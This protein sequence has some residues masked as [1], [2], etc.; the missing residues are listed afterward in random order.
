MPTKQTQTKLVIA[1]GAAAVLGVILW[2]LKAAARPIGDWV[3]S[4][5]ECFVESSGI[6][7]WDHV[8]FN[9]LI[10]SH[11]AEYTTKTVSLL[12]Q[13]QESG[14]WLTAHSYTGTL[15][16]GGSAYY[17]NPPGSVLIAIGE[18]VELKLVDSDG[19]ESKTCKA[20]N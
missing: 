3:F 13:R 12:V 20:V 19:F 4:D 18:T 16:P 7:G 14:I 1:A 17:Q 11:A 9:A 10:T 6:G 5:E 8:I 2:G 15:E